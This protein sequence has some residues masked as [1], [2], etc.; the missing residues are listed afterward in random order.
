MQNPELWNIQMNVHVHAGK[1]LKKKKERK[2][3]QLSNWE[4]QFFKQGIK[5]TYVFW[6]PETEFILKIS[7]H[8]AN[9]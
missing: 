5:T 7:S 2:K 1:E 9:V 4:L 6:R 8:A 3:T